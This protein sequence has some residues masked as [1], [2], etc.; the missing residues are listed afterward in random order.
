MYKCKE[1]YDTGCSCGGI[2]LSCHGCCSCEKGKKARA[3]RKRALEGV[4][5]IVR[6]IRA[7]A[8]NSSNN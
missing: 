3:N 5:A 8:K 6:M 2:G 7:R 4:V 1:C